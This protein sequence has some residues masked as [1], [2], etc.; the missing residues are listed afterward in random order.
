MVHVVG[1]GVERW[2]RHL[3][4]DDAALLPVD[5]RDDYQLRHRGGHGRGGSAF[6]FGNECGVDRSGGALDAWKVLLRGRA[7]TR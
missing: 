3:A 4:S 6:G 1:D 2:G 5:G 7:S